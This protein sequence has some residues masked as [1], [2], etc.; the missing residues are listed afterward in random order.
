M[1]QWRISILGALLSQLCT[2]STATDSTVNAASCTFQGTPL[3]GKI[4]IVESFPDVKV[5][6]VNT[7]PDLKV[8]T[9]TA[10]PED[11]GEWQLVEHFP[12]L[13]V[14]IVESFP[15]LRVQFVEAFPGIP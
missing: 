6:I 12:D 4:K 10:F 11:C 14:Q 7:F 9:V 1:K 2:V 5:K 15:D 13:T 8:K 3:Y